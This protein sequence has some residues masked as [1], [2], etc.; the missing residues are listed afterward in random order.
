MNDIKL[1]EALGAEIERA[2]AAGDHDRA[3]K[4]ADLQ[5]R[6]IARISRE[7]VADAS[8]VPLAVPLRVVPA[9]EHTDR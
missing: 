9:Q 5:C 3:H 1:V 8:A 2:T 4:L 6:V 7:I